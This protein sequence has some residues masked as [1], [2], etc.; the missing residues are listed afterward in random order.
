MLNI[1][2]DLETA[3]E[4]STPSGGGASR[5]SAIR[6]A[7]PRNGAVMVA[8]PRAFW[9]ADIF[10]QHRLAADLSV[11]PGQ[12]NPGKEYPHTTRIIATSDGAQGPHPARE[13]V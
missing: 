6:T 11:A 2:S 12:R 7:Q 9:A 10:G 1:L 4:A 5:Q 3:A 13:P 8:R